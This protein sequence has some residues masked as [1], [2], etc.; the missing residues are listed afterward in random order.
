MRRLAA[1]A[2]L[3]EA[4]IVNTC[5]VTA[6]AE[7][8]ARQ[9]IRKA[10]RERP[11][12]RLIVTGCAAQIDPDGFAAMPEVSQV[13]G[14]ADKM[15]AESWRDLAAFSRAS[16]A[17]FRALVRRE[18]ARLR[19]HGGEG[20]RQPPDRRLRW[21]SPRLRAG[22]ERLR[23]P[24]HLLHHPLRARQFALRADGG[25]RRADQAH[26][27]EGHGGNRAHRR[28][29][30]LLRQ[31]TAGLAEARHAREGDLAPCAGARA[32]S[33]FFHRPGRGG[34]RPPRCARAR[35]SA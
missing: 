32:A 28:R 24:L 20:N 22:A 33:A 13:L 35:T 18:A 17:R 25:G 7:R 14:N 29:S 1:E 34:C 16:A 8:Q 27:R 4:I 2:G 3:A 21:A 23:S 12:A 6:E 30:H 10:A 31:G 15:R 26:R 19:H 9:A 11:H 5:A